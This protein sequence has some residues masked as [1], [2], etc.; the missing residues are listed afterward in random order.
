MNGSKLDLCPYKELTFVELNFL[1]ASPFLWQ[2]GVY[3]QIGI[4]GFEFTK[5]KKKINIYQ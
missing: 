4:L 5:P 2:V 1:F 3:T